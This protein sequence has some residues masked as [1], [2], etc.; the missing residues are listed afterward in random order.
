MSGVLESCIFPQQKSPASRSHSPTLI[1]S[2][3][4][5]GTTGVNNSAP[6]TVMPSSAMSLGAKPSSIYDTIP[7]RHL[8][9]FHINGAIVPLSDDS[10]STAKPSEKTSIYNK[11]HMPFG[12]SPSETFGYVH[13]SPD[14]INT[15]PS[16]SP[17]ILSTPTTLSLSTNHMILPLNH[18]QTQKN[19]ATGDDAL[20]V[21]C[22][23][24]LPSVSSPLANRGNVEESGGNICNSNHV[25]IGLSC[26]ILSTSEDSKLASAKRLHIATADL[27]SNFV[28]SSNELL[29]GKSSVF[30]E[31]EE[32]D[33]TCLTPAQRFKK[34]R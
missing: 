13:V 29:V 28:M 21:T 22:I 11:R 23:A 19:I 5:T 10:N 8:E 17:I 18:R 33:E 25:G 4:S 27:S 3:I 31:S 26:D 20:Q 6:V 30:I 7:S 32:V 15:P 24:P 12:T 2:V 1:T 16:A 14:P 34:V 9:T